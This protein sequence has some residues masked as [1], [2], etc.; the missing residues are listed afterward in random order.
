VRAGLGTGLVLGWALLWTFLVGLHIGLVRDGE[1][2]RRTRLGLPNGLTILRMLLIPA[3]CW[4]I[5]A[6]QRLAANGAV[7]ATLIF[8]V[9]F[10]D[11]LDGW[12]AR[13]TGWQTIL[14]R[15]L[16]HLADLLICAAVALALVV[17]GLMPGWLV[18]LVVFRYLGTGVVSVW[19]IGLQPNVRIIPTLVGRVS[20]VVV[21]MTLFLTL[22]QPLVAPTYKHWMPLIFAVAAV[23]VSLNIISLMWIMFT[24]AHFDRSIRRR[25][26][27]R[28]LDRLKGRDRSRVRDRL[29]KVRDRLEGADPADRAPGKQA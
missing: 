22:A 16:D 29:E 9:G 18:G 25:Y 15:Y 23:F 8:L 21:G 20:T 3:V 4:A 27:L 12:L 11:V 17:A 10:T 28:F 7:A 26:G 2:V 5:L 1:A 14:G 6:H 19:S 13:W 24:G